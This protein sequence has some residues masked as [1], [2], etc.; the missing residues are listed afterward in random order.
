MLDLVAIAQAS[1]GPIA[2]NGAVAVGY[3]LA[4]LPGILTAVAGAILPPF[5]ILTLISLFYT[6]FRDNSVIQALLRGMRA[7]VCAVILSVV[8]DMTFGMMKARDW[9]L[10]PMMLTAFAAN[11]FFHVSAVWII[12]TAALLG[13]L[14]TVLRAKRGGASA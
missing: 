3:K 9:V 7:G 8:C 13:V 14:R 6:A 4:G 2:V 12:L 1:P 10:I 5:V 11:Y